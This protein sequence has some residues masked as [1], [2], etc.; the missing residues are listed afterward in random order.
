MFLL[1]KW[2]ELII[3]QDSECYANVCTSLRKAGIEYKDK[4]QNV[5][6]GNRRYGEIGAIGEKASYSNLYQIFVKKAD[7]ETA[8]ALIFQEKGHLRN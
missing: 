4:I 8:K 3:T 5:G 6:H 2:V 7:L 1:S